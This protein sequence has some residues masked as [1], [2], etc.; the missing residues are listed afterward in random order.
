[1]GRK[2]TEVAITTNCINLYIA[3]NSSLALKFAEFHIQNWNAMPCFRGG[4]LH[5]DSYH[6]TFFEEAK[7][8]IDE[9]FE[10][11]NKFEIKRK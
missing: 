5:G 3:N 10:I 1:M 6:T 7:E 11:N 8:K 2:K 4:G 9:F